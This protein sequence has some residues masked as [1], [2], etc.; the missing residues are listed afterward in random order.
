MKVHLD[1]L[2]DEPYAWQESLAFT[3]HDLGNADLL[4]LSEVDCRGR[5]S[6]SASGFLLEIS[7]AYEQTLNCTRC[8]GEIVEPIEDRIELLLVVEDGAA[9]A[10]ELE[11]REDD[12]GI[13]VLGRPYLETRPLVEQQVQLNVP[14]RALC[15]DDCAG[16]CPDCGADL[17]A[18]PCD[19]RRTTDPRWAGLARWKHE[20][21]GD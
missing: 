2:G 6:R 16:I 14:M 12:L 8:L 17:N 11:L 19:C 9:P 4:A 21:G 7:L 5:L 13:L 3:R 1:R 10:E 15:R 18:G 20:K